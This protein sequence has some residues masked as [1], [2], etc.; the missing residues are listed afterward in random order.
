M[1]ALNRGIEQ[2]FI[3]RDQQH[4]GR[5]DRADR[6]LDPA[7]ARAEKECALRG[8]RAYPSPPMS[9]SPPRPPKPNQEV[10]ERGQGG[11][12]ATTHDAYRAAPAISG[13]EYRIPPPQPS[14]PPP[15]PAGRPFALE[16]S[17]RVP[18][19]YRRSEDIMGRSVTYHVPPGQMIPQPQYPLPPVAGP[20]LG[21]APYPIS[22]SPSG[23]E[24]PPFTSP[25]SQR[26]TKGHV[27]SAC[28]PCKRAHLR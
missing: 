23:P 26:K 20:G 3:P 7:W 6:A 4:R 24:N 27:A 17:E 11:F 25:K 1:Q 12:Q 8:T 28:V 18:Y 19:P 22:A 15:L 21:H 14:L 2:L 5:P 13:P 16:S 9:G 10:A